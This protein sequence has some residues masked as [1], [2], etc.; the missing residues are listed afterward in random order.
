MLR[1]A[2][3]LALPRRAVVRVA[4]RPR[5]PGGRPPV[6]TRLYRQLPRQDF[7]LQ[8][9]AAFHGARQRIAAERRRQSTSLDGSGRERPLQ[10]MVRLSRLGIAT[11]L[12]SWKSLPRPQGDGA[13]GSR[14]PPALSPRWHRRPILRNTPSPAVWNRSTGP[15]QERSSR[16]CT[17]QLNDRAHGSPQSGRH[18]RNRSR[19]YSDGP[20]GGSHG[21]K[22]RP[23]FDDTVSYP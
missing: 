4:R 7:H 17:H 21:N 16:H 14:T 2:D 13:G 11:C 22:E 9:R 3:L 8:E 5:L 18:L 1:P 20:V 23:C 10:P 12:H 19:D 15:P 6:A